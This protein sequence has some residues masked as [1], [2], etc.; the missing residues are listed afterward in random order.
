MRS[1]ELAQISVVIKECSRTVPEYRSAL[2]IALFIGIAWLYFLPWRSDRRGRRAAGLQYRN[3][4]AFDAATLAR[5]DRVSDDDG[6]WFG[7]RP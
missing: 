4:L 6:A 3:A 1:L 7:K 2:R 5:G